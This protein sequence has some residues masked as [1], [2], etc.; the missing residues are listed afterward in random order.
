MYGVRLQRKL[1]GF[2]MVYDL[3]TN[4]RSTFYYYLAGR[5]NWNGIA[6]GCSHP[7]TNPNRNTMHTLDRVTDQLAAANVTMTKAPDLRYAAQNADDVLK[8]FMLTPKK[9]IAVVPGGSAHRPEKRW[10]HFAEFITQLKKENQQVALIGGPDEKE[11]LSQLAHATGAANLCGE[12]NL[13]QLIDVLSKA[14]AAVGNDT[15]PMHIAAACD[16]PCTVLFGNAS[17][18]DLCA[19]RSKQ[20]I[21]LQEQD[22]ASISTQ[23]VRDTLK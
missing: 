5:P 14:K 7:Q 6:P 10:P 23:A 21:I 16:V 11:L 22:I 20:T 2:D 18:P 15:G 4:N 1:K 3:Q 12:T 8:K 9:F 19:P 13:R 17:N